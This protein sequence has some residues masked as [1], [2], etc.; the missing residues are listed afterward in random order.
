VRD[1]WLHL[2]DLLEQHTKRGEPRSLCELLRDF[3][4]MLDIAA[5]DRERLQRL[6]PAGSAPPRAR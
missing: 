6:L 2:L 3:G 4:E 5:E 1:A